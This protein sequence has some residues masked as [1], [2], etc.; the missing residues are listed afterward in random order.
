MSAEL[1]PFNDF[2]GIVLFAVGAILGLGVLAFYRPVARVPVRLASLGLLWLV[3]W[4]VAWPAIIAEKLD[5]VLMQ[6]ALGLNAWTAGQV[7]SAVSAFGQLLG[8]GLL[9]AAVVRGTRIETID[10]R[11]L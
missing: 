11:E 7:L 9:V 10:P 3:F 8:I 4:R 1:N 6:P 2:A 5:L